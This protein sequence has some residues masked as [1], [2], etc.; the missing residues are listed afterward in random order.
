MTFL[1]MFKTKQATTSITIAEP[2]LPVDI[3]SVVFDSGMIIPHNFGE[4]NSQALG[5]VVNANEFA[6]YTINL[7]TDQYPHLFKDI[8]IKSLE[9]K[10]RYTLELDLYTASEVGNKLT[11][12]IFNIHTLEQ[13]SETIWAIRGSGD[14]LYPEK[15]F[16]FRR[17]Q[18]IFPTEDQH[19][20]FEV[21]AMS[22]RIMSSNTRNKPSI[23]FS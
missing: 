7:L 15:I 3:E 10:S 4:I 11:A 8:T 1:D 9:L 14:R 2:S 20:S 23:I 21:T 16:S 22:Y 19:T 18:M 13:Y 5:K 17:N 12:R 6:R